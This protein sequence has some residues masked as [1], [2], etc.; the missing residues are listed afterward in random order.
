LGTSPKAPTSAPVAPLNCI[1]G[2]SFDSCGPSARVSETTALASLGWCT[3]MRPT[4]AP[5]QCAEACATMGASGASGTLLPDA[6]NWSR[7]PPGNTSA[8]KACS[9][10]RSL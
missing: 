6:L 9:P 8:K 2:W 10:P 1:D 5:F 7:P 4:A 3:V